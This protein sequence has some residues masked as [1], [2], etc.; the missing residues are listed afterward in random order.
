MANC[1]YGLQAECTKDCPAF[2]DQDAGPN[3][4]LIG[5]AT[6]AV[7]AASATDIGEDFKPA[8][9]KLAKLTETFCTVIEEKLP[10]IMG[11]MFEELDLDDKP[12][13]KSKKKGGNSK[14]RRGHVRPI[15]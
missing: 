9:R 5:N 8:M 2:T 11:K 1:L 12:G 10:T 6:D 15:R 4:G 13:P 7:N 14:P 3:C